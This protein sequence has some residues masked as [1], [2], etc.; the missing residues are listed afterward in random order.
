MNGAPFHY[1]HSVGIYIFASY[2]L[3]FLRSCFDKKR[4][5]KQWKP[6][7]V[8]KQG[9]MGCAFDG[10]FETIKINFVVGVFSKHIKCTYIQYLSKGNSY[11]NI[12]IRYRIWFKNNAHISD[13][14]LNHRTV[15]ADI[16]TFPTSTNKDKG[17]R[18]LNNRYVNEVVI[19]KIVNFNVIFLL[20]LRLLWN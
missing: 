15:C 18:S 9:D 3:W 1:S 13:A 20:L 12:N 16:K 10:V 2:L 8:Q 19:S 5:E 17:N 4:V 14:Y 6:A 7:D 11:N